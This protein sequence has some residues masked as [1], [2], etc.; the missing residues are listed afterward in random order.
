[1]A[2]ITQSYV[3]D[4]TTTIFNM[5][6]K[7]WEEN[8][9][10]VFIDGVQLLSSEYSISGI[11]VSSTSVDVT[12]P[13]AVDYDTPSVIE[14]R[15]DISNAQ[16]G[17]QLT[18]F[19]SAASV[20]PTTLN[21][22]FA[23]TYQTITGVQDTADDSASQIDGALEPVGGGGPQP[24]LDDRLDADYSDLSGQIQSND[25]D[26]S[27][28]QGRVDDLEDGDAA[29]L[30]LDPSESYYDAGARPVRS[31]SQDYTDPRNLVAYEDIPGINNALPNAVSL[32]NI[33]RD[34]GGSWVSSSLVGAPGN[35]V[36]VNTDSLVSD[37]NIEALVNGL[38]SQL[39]V[40]DSVTLDEIALIAQGSDGRTK[41][42]LGNAGSTSAT[43]ST[44]DA[45]TEVAIIA[46]T[47]RNNR[48]RAAGVGDVILQ[49]DG[50]VAT[51][52]DTG[53]FEV[54]QGGQTVSIDGISLTASDVLTVTTSGVLT[55]AANSGLVGNVV[56][57]FD[58]NATVDV[59][60]EASQEVLLTSGTSMSLASAG[61]I[62]QS[63][64]SGGIILTS[65]TELDLTSTSSLVDI[66]AGTTVD[67]DATT[68]VTIDTTSGN[69]QL[70]PD[71]ITSLGKQG[72]TDFFSFNADVA[73]EMALTFNQGL[74]PN[75]QIV[76]DQG[77]GEL[78]I[79]SGA[80]GKI[81]IDSLGELEITSGN[82]I[83]LDPAY[84]D[85]N[86]SGYTWSWGQRVLAVNAG[87]IMTLPDRG[88]TSSTNLI[89]GDVF[90]S[91]AQLYWYDGVALKRI[92]TVN[93]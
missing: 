50:G 36:T 10:A 22:E 16:S 57:T 17:Q 56:G 32:G 25:G 6:H 41:I 20:R 86:V 21:N 73:G 11:G 65:L 63:A 23:N 7:V 80:L 62:N 64:P 51:L 87:A 79:A 52:L 43:L 3:L 29:S 78:R 26:I 88:S 46:T 18:Q 60:I 74:V 92:T 19:T 76:A 1:M 68:G 89:A 12:V 55:V 58:L 34:T 69:I 81:A 75:A 54:Q 30:K 72:S 2:L 49:T 27:I 33:L 67:I 59:D 14:L 91:G 9:L 13:S 77:A 61:N 70:T 84:L 8:H 48:L 42:A 38:D 47:G 40:R 44:D 90:R 83:F 35:L 37:D 31:T 24:T 53:I 66:N 85:L 15:L 93:A 39:C 71:G 28:L 82:R 5:P 4:G 45:G